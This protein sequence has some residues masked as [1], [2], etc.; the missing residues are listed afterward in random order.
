MAQKLGLHL[1]AGDFNS[2]M[3]TDRFNKEDGRFT[4]G[5]DAR[6]AAIW[7]DVIEAGIGCYELWQKEAT[8]NGPMSRSRIDRVYTTQPVSDQLDHVVAATPL[9]WCP[10]LSQHRPLLFIRRRRQRDAAQEKP[11]RDDIV[12]HPDWPHRV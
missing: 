11:L 5:A 1:V 4:G 2:V 6:E 3:S 8:H 9:E 12:L 10:H 7:R